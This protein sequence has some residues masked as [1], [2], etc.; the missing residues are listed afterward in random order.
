MDFYSKLKDGVNA[1]DVFAKKNH[2][3]IT[4][5]DRDGTEG[6]LE[7]HE[8]SLNPLGIVHGGALLALADTVAGTAA[9][10]NGSECVTLDCAMQFLSPGT[11]TKIVCVARPK[12][13]GKTILVYDVTLTRDDGKTVAG[14][15]YTFFARGPVNFENFNRG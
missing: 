1:G 2:V 15:T 3:T 9:Y 7:I 13:V 4:K 14:G 12:K 5:V 8:D 11:G 6:V 10:S